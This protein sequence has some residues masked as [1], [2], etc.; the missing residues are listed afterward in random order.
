MPIKAFLSVVDEIFRPIEKILPLNIRKLVVSKSYE[1]ERYNFDER[2]LCSGV[3]TVSENGSSTT[4]AYRDAY[5][6][7]SAVAAHYPLLALEEM[8]LNLE[9]NHGSILAI[10]G[11]RKDMQYRMVEN[12]KGF[13]CGNSR[14]KTKVDLFSPTDKIDRLGT[15]AEHKLSYEKWLKRQKKLF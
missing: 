15:V 4:V 11:C 2:R 13:V 5:I 3:L 1:V 8:R 7:I 9:D 6:S 12:Y 10:N 14:G